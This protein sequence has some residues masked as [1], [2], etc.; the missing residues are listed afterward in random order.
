MQTRRVVLKSAAARTLLGGLAGCATWLDRSAQ[1]MRSIRARPITIS[2]AG[3]TLTH[4]DISAA[5]Q[6]SCVLGQSSSVAQ[7]SSGKGCERIARQSGWRANDCR[8][9]DFRYRSRRQFIGRGFAG[10]RR[11]YLAATGLWFDPPL[12]MRLRYV[13][14][15]TLVLPAV[16]FNMASKYTGIRA[17]I[18]K[19]AT[20]GKAT[21][22]QEL[23]LKAA[24][25]AS[26]ATGVPVTTHTAASQR[27]GERGRPP[28]L[29]PKLEPSRVCIGHSDD[30]D[31][32]SYLTALLRGYL[33][34]LDHIPHSAIGLEDNAS[35]SPL[36]GIRSWQ[37][38]ALLIKALIDQGYM[39]QILVSND[40]L[41]GFSSYVTNIMDVMD[42][43]NPDGMAF[44][45]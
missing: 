42:R 3:F 13:E 24:A 39:K 4:E 8:C 21:P 6:D 15:L 34:G 17:G 35:A 20:T 43:V 14:E 27:D 40:W 2:E 26:L 1:A 31:D 16:R 37:T 25:R 36:L 9:V 29:S 41:F 33:I 32:L 22:F 28:F 23:V 11:S 30:T 44:I 18:I 19:V 10:C 5:R 12:S 7:S 38:R 45:H